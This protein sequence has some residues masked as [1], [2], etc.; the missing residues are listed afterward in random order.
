LTA[1]FQLFKKA[2]GRF[3]DDDCSS[4][5]AALS[6]YVFDRASAAHDAA[7]YKEEP[8][9]KSEGVHLVAV[10]HIGHE[11]YLHVGIAG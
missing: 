1:K 8:A 10:D 5:A 7:G 4:R 9:G 2:A 6:S 3:L 11:R